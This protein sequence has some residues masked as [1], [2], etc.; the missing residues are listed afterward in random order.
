MKSVDS[1]ED[2]EDMAGVEC[3]VYG[4]WN[5]HLLG[6]PLKGIHNDHSRISVLVSVLPLPTR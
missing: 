5:W 2:N 3:V 6:D 4:F 1:L